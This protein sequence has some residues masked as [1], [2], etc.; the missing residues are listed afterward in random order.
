MVRHWN[1]GL[2]REPRAV[3]AGRF[4]GFKGRERQS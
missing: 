3:L 1:K 2:M 4:G